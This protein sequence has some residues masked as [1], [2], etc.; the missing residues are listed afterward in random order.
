ME[1][2]SKTYYYLFDFPIASR[3]AETGIR[4]LECGDKYDY[5]AITDFQDQL[6]KWRCPKCDRK[7]PIT[8]VRCAICRVRPDGSPG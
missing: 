8:N 7:W 5:S 4:C 6:E 1:C 3:E 2:R